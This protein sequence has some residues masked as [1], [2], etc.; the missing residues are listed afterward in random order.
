MVLL[1]RIRRTVPFTQEMSTRY[2]AK[3]VD[4]VKFIAFRK[5]ITQESTGR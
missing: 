1:G 3:E 4:C 5:S 2:T